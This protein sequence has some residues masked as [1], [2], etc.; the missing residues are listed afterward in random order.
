MGYIVN[1]YIYVVHL[2]YSFIHFYVFIYSYLFIYLCIYFL[3]VNYIYLGWVETTSWL[4]FA[5]LLNQGTIAFLAKYI[6]YKAT[7]IDLR[8]LGDVVILCPDIV[9]F[10]PRLIA[11]QAGVLQSVTLRP[12]D[13]VRP[14]EVGHGGY[15]FFSMFF[16][17][18]WSCQ[19]GLQIGAGNC[20]Y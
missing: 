18:F 12:P 17:R 19:R 7:D 4:G 3:F 20:A 10:S 16:S 2:F 1:I 13:G 8:S 9:A 15:S 5:A 11:V 14:H 6:E